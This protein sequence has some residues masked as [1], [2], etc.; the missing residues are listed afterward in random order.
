MNEEYGEDIENV[1]YPA[2][3]G[4]LKELYARIEQLEKDNQCRKN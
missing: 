2:L 3:I 4:L 1:S